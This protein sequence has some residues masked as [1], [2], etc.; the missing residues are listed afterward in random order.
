MRVPMVK[1]QW[2]PEVRFPPVSETITGGTDAIS[3]YVY[4]DHSAKVSYQY[5]GLLKVFRRSRAA[6]I[7]LRRVPMVKP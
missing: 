4:G 7:F 1:P 2:V 3:W 5:K 6:F